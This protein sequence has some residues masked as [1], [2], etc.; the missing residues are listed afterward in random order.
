[1]SLLGVGW[2]KAWKCRKHDFEITLT[3]YPKSS[4]GW[5]TFYLGLWDLRPFGARVIATPIFPL[6]QALNSKLE[7]EQSGIPKGRPYLT[8]EGVWQ[9]RTFAEFKFLLNSSKINIT[10]FWV[11]DVTHS[12][13]YGTHTLFNY[14]QFKKIWTSLILAIP[15]ALTHQ[16]QIAEES[17]KP[18][19]INVKES[20]FQTLFASWLRW[21]H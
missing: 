4:L 20:V 8:G 18:A 21:I 1:M 17:Y 12:T 10:F 5:P 6:I 16:Y 9:K 19:S 7:N 11:C 15:A 3:V 2:V 13:V 14:V